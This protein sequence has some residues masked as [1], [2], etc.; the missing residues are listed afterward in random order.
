LAGSKKFVAGK[1]LE[2]RTDVHGPR[3][4]LSPDFGTT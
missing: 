1:V 4:S 2:N 3:G